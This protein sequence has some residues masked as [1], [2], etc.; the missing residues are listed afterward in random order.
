MQVLVA[1]LDAD[2]AILSRDELIA[3]CWHSRI[4]GDDSISSVV[5]RLRRDLKDVAS[6]ALKIETVT[7]VGFRL[8][9]DPREAEVGPVPRRLADLVPQEALAGEVVGRG[10]DPGQQE[11]GG[12]AVEVPGL[13]ID[14]R[15]SNG[16]PPTVMRRAGR[17]RRS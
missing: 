9:V 14:H 4:V 3:S 12:G 5:Y 8:V 2:G 11:V 16:F 10:A 7:K 17:A 6:E 13:G 15:L 1:L